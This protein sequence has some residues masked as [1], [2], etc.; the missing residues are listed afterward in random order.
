MKDPQT[1]EESFELVCKEMLTVFIKKHKDYGKANILESGELGIAF[2]INDKVS[3][4]KH[5]LTN[6]NHPENELLEDSW[7]DIAVYAVIGI[8]LLRGWFQKHHLKKT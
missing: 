2:R 3:R 7:I 4:L 6:N 8:M 1:L 5:L